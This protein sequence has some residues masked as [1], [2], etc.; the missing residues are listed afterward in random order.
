M[1]LQK[2]CHDM[3]ILLWL[4]G[5]ALYKTY[6]LRK[7]DA[8]L[9]KKMHQKMLRPTVWTDVYTGMNVRILHLDSIWRI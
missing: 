1:I 5:A 4:V 2:C 7:S 9:K 6:K 3:D 8:F